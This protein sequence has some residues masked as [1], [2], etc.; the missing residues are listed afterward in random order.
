MW[1]KSPQSMIKRVKSLGCCYSLP[2]TDW[3]HWQDVSIW[4]KD[5]L[6]S[7]DKCD[8]L[9]KDKVWCIYFELFRKLSW[10]MQI[11]EVSLTKVETIEQLISKYT[12]K[13]L[14]IPN[15]LTNVTLY[16]SSMKLKLL[17]LSLVEEFTLG[18]AQLF[19]K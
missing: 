14:G 4:L 19:Q 17:T 10:Q 12:T 9:N 5:G 6:H 16:S 2:L 8:L 1:T 18:K 13:W 3:H 15:S 7:I 11:Y